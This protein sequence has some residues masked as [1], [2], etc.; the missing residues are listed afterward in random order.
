ME[1]H[2]LGH[3]IR[4]GNS[5]AVVIP[6]GLLRQLDIVKG[7]V[8]IMGVLGDRQIGIRVLLDSEVKQYTPVSIEL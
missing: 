7:D 5:L 6:V 2:Y 3:I 4:I 1:Y 8:V